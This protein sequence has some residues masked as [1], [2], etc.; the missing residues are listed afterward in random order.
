MEKKKKHPSWIKKLRSRYRLLLINE[1][2]FQEKATVKLTPLSVIMLFSAGFLLF[3]AISWLLIFAI[4]PLRVYM[5]GYEQDKEKKF[6][7][8]V[9]K[10][11]KAYETTIQKLEERNILLDIILRGDELKPADLALLQDEIDTEKEP[12]PRERSGIREESSSELSGLIVSEPSE[13]I[14]AFVGG[15]SGLS[16]MSGL[17]YPPL[18]GK[19]IANTSP[20]SANAVQILPIK[21]FTV[22]AALDGTVIY[23]AWT[24]LFGVVI[25]LQHA[26]N[27]LTVYKN[28]ALSYTQK[29]ARV[30]AGEVIAAL[31]ANNNEASNALIFELWHDGYALNPTQFIRFSN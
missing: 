24:P 29:G 13:N 9:L 21:D 20:V 6:K 22:K 17:F 7:K 25:C 23:S 26:D 18:I 30:N 28:C 11:L 4:P 27:W 8:E 16:K 2:D 19:S 14:F 12:I 10:Q 31:P 5:P 3:F 15:K 1:T